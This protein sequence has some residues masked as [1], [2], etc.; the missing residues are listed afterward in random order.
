ME[1]S[2]KQSV[3]VGFS[4]FNSIK[5]YLYSA[6][7]SS[8]VSW[9]FTARS[10]QE[11]QGRGSLMGRYARTY[12]MAVVVWVEGKTSVGKDVS[13]GCLSV[14]WKRE[15]SAIWGQLSY[16]MMHSCMHRDSSLNQWF[17][18]GLALGPQFQNHQKVATSRPDGNSR[19]M[20]H[21][22]HSGTGGNIMFCFY[23]VYQ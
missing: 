2:Y 16:C 3:M 10:T 18:T 21:I 14:C 6:S 7:H 1:W 13:L 15:T 8:I 5:L 22:Q 4:S 12:G 23:I 20:L 17:L 9:C 11:Q 19:I